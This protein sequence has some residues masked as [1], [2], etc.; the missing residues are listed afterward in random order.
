MKIYLGGMDAAL[1][2]SPCCFKYHDQAQA[3]DYH[4]GSLVFFSGK[5][6]GQTLVAHCLFVCF[7]H[8]LTLKWI[9]VLGSIH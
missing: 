9:G 3:Q 2:F 6:L 8:F 5:Q 7:S 1:L 4:W